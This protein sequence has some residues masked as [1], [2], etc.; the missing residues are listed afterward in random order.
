MSL[1]MQLAVFPAANPEWHDVMGLLAMGGFCLKACWFCA[2]GAKRCQAGIEPL[3]PRPPHHFPPPHTCG[4]TLVRGVHIRGRPRRPARHPRA[5]PGGGGRA[6]RQRP[7][8]GA[9]NCAGA[10]VT[11]NW[12]VPAGSSQPFLWVKKTGC[13]L[14]AALWPPLLWLVSRQSA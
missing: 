10:A 12:L 2:A 9:A 3:I 5:R 4:P 7:A 6:A 1:Q 13:V 11:Q 14:C 8:Q